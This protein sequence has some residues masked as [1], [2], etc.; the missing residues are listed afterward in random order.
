MWFELSPAPGSDADD[1]QAFLKRARRAVEALGLASRPSVDTLGAW[2]KRVDGITLVASGSRRWLRLPDGAD[3]NAARMLAAACD[4]NAS[5]CE[6]PGIV[7]RPLAWAHAIVPK[8]AT[9]SRSARDELEDGSDARIDPPADGLVY[10]TVRR[11]GVFETG[12]A[13]DW[14][15]DEFNMSPDTSKLQEAGVGAARVGAAMPRGADAT[16]WAV[17]AANA[18][19]L[20]LTPGVSAH[21]SRPRLGGFLLATILVTVFMIALVASGDWW[22]MVAVM[23]AGVGWMM[24]LVR[25][26]RARG[27]DDLEC[28]PRHWWWLVRMRRATSSD[29]KTRGA[30]DDHNANLKRRVHAYAYQ[31]STLPLP[32][33]TLAALCRPPVGEHAR[34][35]RATP[36]PVALRDADGPLLGYGADGT[37]ARLVASRLWGGVM[38]MGRPGSGK[39]NSLH[40]LTAW[41]CSHLG[42]NGVMVVFESKGAGSIPILKRLCGRL[43]V[44]DVADPATPMIS[45]T[46]DG[47]ASQRAE[48]FADLMRGALGD[49]Q[50]GPA[51]RLQLRDAVWLALRDWDETRLSNACMAAGVRRPDSWLRFAFVLLAGHGAGEARALARALTRTDADAGVHAALERLHGGVNA[52]SGRP[53][54]SDGE[55]VKRLYAPMNKISILADV[56]AL[57]TSRREVTW[58]QVIAH[59]SRLVVNLGASVD[60]HRLLGSDATN[61]VGA[62]LFQG[63]RRQIEASCVSWQQSSR[64]M[65]VSVDELTSILGV[66]MSGGAGNRDALEWLRSRGREYGV[67]LK[68]GTQ[69]PEQLDPVTLQLVCGFDTFAC[70]AMAPDRVADALGVDG[71][72]VSGLGAHMLCA[73]TVDADGG[74]LPAMTVRVPWFDGGRD[75]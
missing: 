45:L 43:N 17:R 65:C 32:S 29:H 73:R 7:D 25:L 38:L 10:I 24:S 53:Q 64:R 6:R 2:L 41:D 34:R 40:G 57:N 42:F 54:V 8:S 16:M 60:G 31:R 14:L 55:L 12:R 44:V 21:R 39:S 15:G 35:S 28:R 50:I 33:A 72:V 52:T 23:L 3:V 59:S 63:L 26:V 27:A 66:D 36:V 30:G 56:E 47:D 49:T 4:A 58:R 37:P 67:E 1:Q 5:E 20:G 68:C 62:L 11:Q 9:L 69:Y 19:D 18:F 70:Y 13:K 74:L 61:L 22:A 75:A 48:R 71:Q 51:S 46:G